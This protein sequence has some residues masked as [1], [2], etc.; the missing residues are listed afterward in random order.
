MSGPGYLH[1][2]LIV[3]YHGCDREVARR[4]LMDGEDLVASANPY[5]WLGNGVYFWEHGFTR[6]H[7]FAEEKRGRGEITDPFV[8]GAYVHL[9]NCLDLTDLWATQLLARDFKR[10]RSGARRRG[11][12]LPKNKKARAAGSDVLLRYLD[13]AVINYCLERSEKRGH[14]DT[15]R[16]VF[17]EGAPAYEGA[18]IREKSHVQVAVRNPAC[19]LG[20]FRPKGYPGEIGDVSR[21]Q[22]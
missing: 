3:G 2:R 21:A 19:I 4:V 7:Q 15:V 20:Y 9:G 13:C 16:G 1:Q 14:Y 18:A 6:A 10:L 22:A 11:H 17:E 8:I 12:A 5:D